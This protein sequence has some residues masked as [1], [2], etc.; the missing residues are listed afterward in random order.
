MPSTFKCGPLRDRAGGTGPPMR[1]PSTHAVVDVH[2]HVH[3]EA[4][5]TL[6]GTLYDP[7][8][9][10]IFGFASARSREVIARRWRHCTPS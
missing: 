10:P 9:D 1:A 4:A 6:V 5:E 7:A 8:K 3:I 2:C